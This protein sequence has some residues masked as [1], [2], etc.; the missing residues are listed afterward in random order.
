[1]LGDPLDKPYDGWKGPKSVLRPMNTDEIETICDRNLETDDVQSIPEDVLVNVQHVVK[2]YLPGMANADVTVSHEK[3]QCNGD[4]HTCPT[5]QRKRLRKTNR[6]P[7][8]SLITL[9]KTITKLNKDHPSYAR[10]T[11]DDKGKLVKLAVSR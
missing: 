5:S 9:N 6:K 11:M 8:R 4:G 3:E 2:Q 10:L 7:K 1:M